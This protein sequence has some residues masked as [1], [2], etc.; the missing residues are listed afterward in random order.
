LGRGGHQFVDQRR[1]PSVELPDGD[2]L[3]WLV[4]DE[5]SPARVECPRIERRGPLHPSIAM[6]LL[7][8]V[9]HPDAELD[10]R[11]EPILG[12]GPCH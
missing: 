11:A 10:A 3:S 9:D 8:E 1:R 2:T 7:A 5:P 12:P 6:A 4:L